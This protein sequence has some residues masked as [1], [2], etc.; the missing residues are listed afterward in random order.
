[1]VSVVTAA[2]LM[3]SH[4]P[5]NPE[6]WDPLLLM[7]QPLSAAHPLPPHHF[8]SPNSALDPRSVSLT[9]RLQSGWP[10]DFPTSGSNPLSQEGGVLL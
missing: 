4:Q 5:E 7:A 8:S 3:L 9:R 1:M 2:G 6:P 10:Q